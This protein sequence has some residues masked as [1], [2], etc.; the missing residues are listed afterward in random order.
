M[1]VIEADSPSHASSTAADTS[2][3]ILRRR[4]RVADILVVATFLLGG[5]FITL[6]LWVHPGRMVY[7]SNDEVVFEWMLTRA[8]RA[9]T[10]FEN[11]LFS[12]QLNAPDGVNL[13]ANTSV[14][15]L[16]IPLSP[17]TLIFGTH[18][19][20][21]VGTVLSLAGT[22]TS[23]YIM[24]VRAVTTSRL[25]AFIGAAFCGFAPGM[26]S[27]ASGHVN[28]IAQFVVP[29][30]I[31]AVCR[32]GQPGRV[33]R[34]GVILGLLITYQM[35]LSEELLLFIAISIGLFVATYALV[36]RS[37][38]RR[39]MPGFLGGL[40]V[41]ALTSGVLLAYPLWFQ[42]LG[43]GHYRGLPYD[44]DSYFMDVGAYGTYNRQALTGFD[45]VPGLL[46]PNP[47]EENAFF[48][49]ALLV[50]CAVIVAWL[51]RSAVVKAL[52][53][54]AL[55]FAALSLGP[56]IQLN[57]KLTGVPGPQ[58]LIS[59]I[60]LVDLAVPARFPLILV[61]IIGVLLVLSVDRLSAVRVPGVPVRLLWIGAIVAVL[62]PLAP[63]PMKTYPAFPLPEFIS[64]GQWRHYVQPGQSVVAVPPL[65][66]S[67]TIVGMFWSAR[68]GE[69]FAVPGGYFIGPMSPDDKAGRFGAFDRPTGTLLGKV[70]ST[71]RVPVITDQDRQR[72]IADL[73]H[74]RGAVVVLA[75]VSHQNQLRE[76]LD[77]LLGPGRQISD[78]WVWDVRNLGR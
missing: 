40:G 71:G 28:L 61:P 47:T 10:H 41:A 60:P 7:T 16:G 42:F 3:G 76:T 25:A 19:A 66:G 56:T 75:K 32:L 74:W 1:A 20:F 67:D 31:W 65:V 27:Q 12:S 64:G 49:L 38:A 78:A 26:I 24:L 39:R 68:T 33:V 51:W 53:V 54:G 58:R 57:G 34:G 17:I 4:P 62:L 5:A 14:L 18:A 36:N 77:A 55:V 73:K 44:K 43:P 11:P 21:L 9:L 2:G 45:V 13:M 15:G 35:F 63:L 30:I 6:K 48:G 50:L 70:A 37:E 46:S 8:A 59:A 23:W 52:A 69:E 72:A 29:P 22:A